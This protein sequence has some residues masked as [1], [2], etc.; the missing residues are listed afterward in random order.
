MTFKEV[1]YDVREALKLHNVDSDVTDRHI[2]FLIRNARALV[3]RQFVANNPGEY[4]NQL[5]QTIHIPLTLVD[6]SQFPEITTLGHT[7]LSSDYAVPNIIGEQMYKDI[8]VRNIGLISEEIQILDKVRVSEYLYAPNGFI[9]GWRENDGKLYLIG[10]DL[11]YKFLQA[12][13]ITAIFEDPEEAFQLNNENEDIV[14]YPITGALWL[15]VKEIVVATLLKQL[16]MPTD[17][18]NNE[19]EDRSGT[20]TQK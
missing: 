17:A 20:S 19:N 6:T 14:T 10:K 16:G 15:N 8:E 7:L 2:A 18:I 9:Y 4:R 13:T 11:Q 1:I 5:T 3:L 12:V